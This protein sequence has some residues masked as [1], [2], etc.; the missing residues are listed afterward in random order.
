MRAASLASVCVLWSCVSAPVADRTEGPRPVGPVMNQPVANTHC[1]PAVFAR[2][3]ST[4]LKSSDSSGLFGTIAA[5]TIACQVEALRVVAARL[6]QTSHPLVIGDFGGA[7]ATLS[8]FLPSDARADIK[9][10][11]LRFGYH[12]S[13]HAPYFLGLRANHIDIRPQL[14]GKVVEDW[15]FEQP[16]RD[17]E[18]WH[19]YLYLASLDE[20]GAYRRL[21]EKIATTASGNDVTN[22]LTSLAE[23]GSEPAREILLRYASDPR[24]ADGPDGPAM[25]V[26]ATVALLLTRHFAARPAATPPTDEA[27]KR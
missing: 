19:Y 8:R 9:A 16:R 18:T 22:L 26:S 20:P 3:E 23:L 21:A 27:G 6:E 17:A 4:D 12:E 13:I 5:E 11:Y 24:R 2:V 10:A 1:P 14:R 25:P 7:A 15:R